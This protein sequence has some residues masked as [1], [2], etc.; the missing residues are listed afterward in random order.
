MEK[1]KVKLDDIRSAVD[2][3]RGIAQAVPF[4][5]AMKSVLITV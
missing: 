3:Y 4:F 5:Y 1:F 2:L